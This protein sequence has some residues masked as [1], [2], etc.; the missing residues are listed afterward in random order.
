MQA[1]PSEADKALFVASSATEE[2]WHKGK[3]RI[4][5]GARGKWFRVYVAACSGF[6]V[7]GVFGQTETRELPA[8]S[9]RCR[10]CFGKVE[11]MQS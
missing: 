3:E 9:R 11:E 6:Q 1:F 2:L 8:G 5:R 10:R 4:L 7:G